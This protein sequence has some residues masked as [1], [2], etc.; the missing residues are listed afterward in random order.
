M[1]ERVDSSPGVFHPETGNP[2]IRCRAGMAFAML[3]QGIVKYYELERY[4]EPFRVQGRD[5]ARMARGLQIDLRG[6]QAL[7]DAAVQR[8]TQLRDIQRKGI[9]QREEKEKAMSQ[10]VAQLQRTGA[11]QM[12]ATS[13][14][15][16]KMRRLVAVKVQRLRQARSQEP[17]SSRPA[18]QSSDLTVQELDDE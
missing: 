15:L 6:K 12:S 8:E 14:A 10:T 1:L 7:Y 3:A 17:A 9:K 2:D 13:R 16:E 18:L 11:W 4:I 5:A